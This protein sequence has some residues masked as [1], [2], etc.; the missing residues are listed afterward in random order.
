MN[1][2]EIFFS[3][4]D[5]LTELDIQ[6]KGWRGDVIVKIGESLFNPIIITPQRL[7]SEFNDAVSHNQVYDI[8]PNIILV[9]KT[10]KKQ[11]I[12][13]LEVLFQNGYFNKIKGIDLKT[14]FAYS[15]KLQEIKNWIQVF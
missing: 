1:K 9:E 4:D 11:I 12:T 10:E 15:K 3:V 13:T 2:C 6:E 5:E 14:E 8:E 7:I